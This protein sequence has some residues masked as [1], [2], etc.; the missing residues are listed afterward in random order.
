MVLLVFLDYDL[1][2]LCWSG[3]G[4]DVVFGWEEFDVGKLVEE[5]VV[6]KRGCVSVFFVCLFFEVFFM[7]IEENRFGFWGFILLLGEWLKD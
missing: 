5:F 3:G 1:E 2:D 7:D 4:W 6:V